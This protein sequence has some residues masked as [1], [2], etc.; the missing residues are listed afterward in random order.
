MLRIS[1]LFKK[2]KL[3]DLE[4]KLPNILVVGMPQS[5]STALFNIITKCLELNNL[6]YESYLYGQKKKDRVVNKKFLSN[7]YSEN[8]ILV[9]EHHYSEFL[10][11]WAD[12]IFLTKRDIRD[13]IAS[14]RRRGKDLFS[15]GKRQ[16]NEHQYDENSFFGFKQWCNY[17]TFDCFQCWTNVDYVFDYEHYVNNKT[18]VVKEIINTLNLKKTNFYDILKYANTGMINNYNFNISGKITKNGGVGKYSMNLSKEEIQY[19]N[20]YYSY[21]IK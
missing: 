14:R 21:W 12:T 7:Y 17:L 19:I 15:K 20:K 5:G 18:E 10:E 8:I 1:N 2:K 4:K 13:S 16:V 9:K 6:K 3:E 11:Q